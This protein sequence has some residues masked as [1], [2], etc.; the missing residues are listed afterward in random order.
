MQIIWTITPTVSSKKFTAKLRKADT[1]EIVAE[2]PYTQTGSVTLNRLF[3][4]GF[5]GSF[6]QQNIQFLIETT[7]T[8]LNLTYSLQFVRVSESEDSSEDFSATITAGIV[9]PDSLV[10]TIFVQDNIPDIGIL[11]FLTGIFKMFNL[12]AF[13]E[14]DP[15]SDDFGKVVVKTLDSFYS[16]GTSRDITEFVDTSQGE[17]NFSVPFNDIQFKF[18]D[19]KTF[20]AFFFEKLNNRQLGSVKAS[21]TSGSGRDPRLNRGQDYRVQLPFEKMF[22]EKLTD[23]NDNSDTTIGFGYFVDDNQ[24]PVINKPLM[25]FRANTTGTAIQ[26]QDG[27]GTGTPLSITQY[28]RASNF[29]VGTQSVVIA[30]SSGE[31][32]AVSFSYVVPTT[33]AT[34]TVSVSPNSSTT[35]NP[36]VTGS[37]LR[38]ST[39]SSESNVTTTFTTLTTGNTLNFSTEINPFVATVEDNNT[40]FLNFYSKYIRDVFSYNRRLIKVNAILPQK[41]LLR[42]KLS[43]TIVINNTEFY[44]NKITTNLQTGKSKL[45]LLTKVNTIS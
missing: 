3:E 17:S 14:D 19:P 41:F 38:T 34:A 24:A 25:F 9:E 20:G 40:L 29:R 8:S 27:G 7:E 31:S 28:N 18:A 45:E 30:V 42:Y 5:N 10:E 26:M 33:F 36:L 43:D 22:F 6:E 12:T 35:V 13:I 23:G 44:I 37:L 2:Q 21:S 15:S 39:V 11:E 1:G 4:Q 32:S 16:G